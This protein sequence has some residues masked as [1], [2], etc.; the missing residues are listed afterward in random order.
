MI[1]SGTYAAEAATISCLLAFVNA[2]RAA[3][4]TSVKTR[5]TPMVSELVVMVPSTENLY[6]SQIGTM[7]RARMIV[8]MIIVTQVDMRPRS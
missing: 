2:E 4:N 3:E 5:T 1:E 6:S 8:V 7:S